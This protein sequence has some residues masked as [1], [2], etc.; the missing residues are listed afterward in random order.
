MQGLTL[1]TGRLAPLREAHVEIGKRRDHS[2]SW[3]FGPPRSTTSHTLPTQP[4]EFKHSHPSHWTKPV[5]HANT[6]RWMTPRAEPHPQRLASPDIRTTAAP[7]SS[8]PAPRHHPQRARAVRG[9]HIRLQSEKRGERSAFLWAW[10]CLD[11]VRRD[12]SGASLL[13]L[14][15]SLVVPP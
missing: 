11:V 4:H 12:V 7:S 13:E 3:A 1:N 9:T 2:E 14:A 8:S 6:C 10:S 5:F 15:C